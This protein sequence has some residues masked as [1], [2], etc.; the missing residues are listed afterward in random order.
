MSDLRWAVVA[1]RELG[2]ADR[3]ALRE[4]WDDAFGERFSDDDAD[5]AFGGVH[6]IARDDEGRPVAHASAVPRRLRVGE[7]WF[8]AAYVEAV[9]VARARRRQGLGT[10][11][12]ELLADQIAAGWP[13]AMLS[14]G[15]HG[16]Y[17]RLGWRRWAGRSLTRR[18]DGAE[19]FDDEHGGLMV[20]VPDG[21][22]VP[23]L[24]LTLDVV[25]EDRAGDAW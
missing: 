7:T 22:P 19:E 2:D 12:M 18:A 14:T 15:S 9:A 13:F 3:S 5:H 10:I 20:L 6:V 4:L 24:D 8:E 25:C 23:G 21:V 1:S 16:F 11:A 17:E